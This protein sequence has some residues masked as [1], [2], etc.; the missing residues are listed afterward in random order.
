MGLKLGIGMLESGN[1]RVQ[2]AVQKLISDPIEAES[3]RAFD[4]GSRSFFD[5]MR[6]NLLVNS[7]VEE[8]RENDWGR[9]VNGHANRCV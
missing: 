7:S 6:L 8:E 3:C 4:G 9:S 5:K 1:A 2:A